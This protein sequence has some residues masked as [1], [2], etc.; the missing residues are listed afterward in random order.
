[1]ISLKIPDTAGAKSSNKNITNFT[2]TLGSFKSINNSSGGLFYKNWNK[3]V[4]S[5]IKKFEKVKR[6][7]TLNKFLQISVLSK[8][9]YRLLLSYEIRSVFEAPAMPIFTIYDYIM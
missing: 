4:S 3:A 5:S 1:M 9:N 6:L 2:D 8:Y 7:K